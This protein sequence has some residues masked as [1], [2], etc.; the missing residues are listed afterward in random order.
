MLQSIVPSVA[1]VRVGRAMALRPARPH[2]S[3]MMGAEESSAR[4]RTVQRRYEEVMGFELLLDVGGAK[5]VPAHQLSEG[6]L[7]TLGLLTV[8]LGPTQ[9]RLILVDDIDRALHPAALGSLAGQIRKLIEQVPDLQ[10]VAT[11]HSP[12]LADH[13]K[14]EELI[15]GALDES[16]AARFARL[17]DHPE[18]GKWRD[19]MGM[20]E[21][22]STVG[23]G[24]LTE[25]R[26]SADTPGDGSE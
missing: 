24:W 15:V 9:P 4:T 10:V 19:L 26:T 5:E 2:R 25:R 8:I 7:L 6:T 18:L 12:Y 17:S 1:S 11:S 13:L 14:P 20:G 16:G 22:W 21:F 3:A 23:E